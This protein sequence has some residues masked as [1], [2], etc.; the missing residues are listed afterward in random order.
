M[1]AF[2]LSNVVGLVRQI[3]VSE[4]F[5]TSAA[6]DAFNAANRVPDMLFN[7]LAGGALGSAFIPVFTEL[8]TQHRRERAWRLAS[9]LATNLALV[10]ALVGLVT[11]WAAPWVVRTL[12]AP[13]FPP[14]QQELTVRLL[15]IL[16]LTPWIFGLSGLSM[17]VLHV[18]RRFLLP[19]LAPTMY[20]LG[21]IFGV[22]VLARF[23]GIFGLAWG[24]V[25]G[26][27]GHALIQWPDL[28]RLPGRR[29]IPTLGWHMPEVRQVLRLMGPRWLGVAVVQLNFWINVVL[30]SGMPEGSLT[31]LQLAWAVMTMPQV[32]L[33][34]GMAVVALP[35]FSAHAAARDWPA[36]RHSLRDALRWMTLLALPATAGLVLLRVPLIQVLFQRGAFDERSTQL[37]AWALLWYAL[38][39]VAHSIV[40]ILAR[41]FY[42][43][44]D[45]KTPVLVG[46]GAMLLNVG[47]S[48]ALA[49][50]FRTWGW[51]PHGGLALANTLATSLEMLGL[52]VL[53]ARRLKPWP[54]AA[55]WRTWGVSAVATLLMAFPL[56][57]LR[58]L[59]AV[60]TWW[61]LMALVLAA[62][63]V[64][65][66]ALW[67][68]RVPEVRRMVAWSLA[69][70]RASMARLRG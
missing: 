49:A 54:L 60:R 51:F 34:Q 58:S 61:G 28:W 36:L 31:A 12:L 57:A 45:T 39:L 59:P 47:L 18:H 42:A 35:T 8:L 24:A 64:Y 63:V 4:A 1:G 67:A 69:R 70:A 41:A 6:M 30:A 23:W 68:L 3:F 33:A 7:L 13:G 29:Y 56:L 43:L 37:V 46:G 53:I 2:A 17:A 19:A 48:L 52:L 44:Q 50:L 15:R 9:A 26:A 16:L 20:W 40:E 10:F 66:L 25:L 22:V 32:V 21:M 14:A 65:A 38:G 27:L 55:W 62:V 5:G 11:A